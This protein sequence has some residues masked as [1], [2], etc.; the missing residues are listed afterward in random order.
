[1][2]RKPPEDGP[3][4]RPARVR[5]PLT[6][7][8]LFEYAVRALGRRMRTER[9]LRRL[10]LTKA[11]PGQAGTEAIESV[12]RRLVELRYLSDEQFAVDYTRIRKE[13]GKLGRRRVEQ[14]LAQKGISRELATPTLDAAYEGIDEAALA[15]EYCGRKRIRKPA[16]QKEQ[17]R[18]LGRLVRAGFSPAVVFK[19]LREWG[20]EVEE[21]DPE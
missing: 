20:A 9:E 3:R 15:R 6:E 8:G 11:E 17:A 13:G 18:V 4:K 16:D 10:M 2:S 14:D 1:M 5:P 21:F 7:P 12:I 19:L